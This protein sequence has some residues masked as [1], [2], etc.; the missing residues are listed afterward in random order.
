MSCT[1]DDYLCL[2]HHMHT[3]NKL[4]GAVEAIQSAGLVVDRFFSA[5]NYSPEECK[6]CI[7][8][9]FVPQTSVSKH[10]LWLCFAVGSRIVIDKQGAPY[11]LRG[12]QE[13]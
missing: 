12:Y 9:V 6:V 3:Y 5:V 10:P 1:S 7:V 13:R 2:Y 11:V 4:Q 8:C